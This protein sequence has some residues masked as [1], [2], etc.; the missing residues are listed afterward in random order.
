M[1]GFS[2]CAENNNRFRIIG[3]RFRIS[4]LFGR[5]DYLTDPAINALGNFLLGVPKQ[6]ARVADILNLRR[7][8]RSYIAELELANFGGQV[9][10]VVVNSFRTQF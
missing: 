7:G 5:A 8:L 1:R 4:P 10:V 2:L 9:C 3:H 6:S